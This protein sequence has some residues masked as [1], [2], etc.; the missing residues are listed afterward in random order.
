M[1]A[2]L[3]SKEKKEKEAKRKKRNASL[4]AF[5]NKS[6]I[7]LIKTI[8]DY[9]SFGN[10]T[11]ISETTYFCNIPVCKKLLTEKTNIDKRESKIT[12]KFYFFGIPYRVWTQT[13]Y[14][15]DASSNNESST[16]K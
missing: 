8:Q 6:N 14:G 3:H 13:V 4:L 10:D 1:A 2:L 11:K 5:Y 15:K 12:R 7:M 9:Y 16:S